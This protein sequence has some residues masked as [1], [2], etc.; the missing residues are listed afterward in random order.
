MSD[1]GL[2]LPYQ[3]SIALETA[4][5]VLGGLAVGLLLKWL[6]FA[7]LRVHSRH[8]ES[9]VTASVARWLSQPSTYFL[10][11]LVLSF[12][13]PLAPLAPKPFEVLR[14]ITEAALI[15]TFAW[16]LVRVVNVAEDLIRQHYQL[17]EADNLRVRKLYTQLQFVRKFVVSLIIFLAGALI[18][19]GFATVRKIGT[20][21]LTSAGIVSVIVGFAAQRSIS[22]LLAGFQLAFTQPIRIDDVLVVEGEWGRVEE[23]T[24]TYV[25]LRLWDER[26]LVLPLN[27]FIEKPFQNWTRTTSQLLGTALIYTDYTIPVDAVRQELQRIAEAS[28]YWD[29]RVCVL[30][31]TDSKERTLELRALVSAANSGNLWELRCEVREKL[32]AFVQQHYPECLPKTRTE[33]APEAATSSLAGALEP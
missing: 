24:F 9:L 26:R 5:V 32:V 17:T 3:L 20:G 18:L 28:K 11:V 33:S 21:L 14:R 6:V 8:T 23:I 4:G 10:P 31:V 16:C 1:L 27:Y 12:M 25:V 30:H 29:K 13:L 22:N 15:S 7:L 2:D 19:M